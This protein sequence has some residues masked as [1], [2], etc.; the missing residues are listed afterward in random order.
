MVGG[1]GGVGGDFSGAVFRDGYWS[2]RPRIDPPGSIRPK[3]GRSAPVSGTFR[4]NTHRPKY[5][6][7]RNKFFHRAYR[8]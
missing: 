8:R 6:L 4:P 1:V 2:I 7:L 5:K 3:R